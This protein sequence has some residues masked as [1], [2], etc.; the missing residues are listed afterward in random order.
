M[1][2]VSNRAE[3][4]PLRRF[5]D[6]LSVSQ[7]ER[8]LELVRSI[9]PLVDVE[10]QGCQLRKFF[11]LPLV[12]EGETLS[13]RADAKLSKILQVVDARGRCRRW[14]TINIGWRSRTARETRATL[15]ACRSLAAPPGAK[16]SKWRRT[17]CR[18]PL[19]RICR[20]FGSSVVPYPSRTS[21]RLL[22]SLPLEHRQ[23]LITAVVTGRIEVPGGGTASL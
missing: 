12:R 10:R 3:Q 13:G 6:L 18:S 2:G 14:R 16:P 23:D 21:R 8:V 1:S 11:V 19:R 4:L 5:A 9:V 15:R 17:R 20:R 22:D 7:D